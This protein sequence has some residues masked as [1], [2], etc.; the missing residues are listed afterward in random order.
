MA[1]EYIFCPESGAKPAAVLLSIDT[2]NIQPDLQDRILAEGFR[3]K[4]ECHITIAQSGPDFEAVKVRRLATALHRLTTKPTHDSEANLYRVAK[5]KQIDS[6]VI[7][8]YSLVVPVI[9][10]AIEADME[11]VAR[12]HDLEVPPRFLHVTLA[13]S[14]DT[15]VARRG[16]GIANTQTWQALNA[17]LYAKNWQV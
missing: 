14:P 4:D 6:L 2:P 1:S 15:A 3:L 5:P 7:P 16:I 8:R 12:D 17:E 10:R 11:F 13:T 9:S